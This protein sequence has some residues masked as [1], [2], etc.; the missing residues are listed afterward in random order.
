MI[1]TCIKDTE[2]PLPL[3]CD[4]W[5][6]QTEIDLDDIT[7]DTLEELIRVKIGRDYHGASV[8]EHMSIFSAVYDVETIKYIILV[9]GSDYLTEYVDP[10]HNGNILHAAAINPNVE[11]AKVIINS[12]AQDSLHKLAMGVDRID[13]RPIELVPYDAEM[14]ALFIQ[15]T[16][17][18]DDYKEYLQKV[19]PVARV[20]FN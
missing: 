14:F 17:I 19:C 8:C 4:D 10:R 15:I 11:V 18:D 1:R 9:C 13:R 3:Y 7:P 6:I 16:D 20:V 2:I 12:I 5:E